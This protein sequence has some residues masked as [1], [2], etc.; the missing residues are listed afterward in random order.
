VGQVSRLE[1][2]VGMGPVLALLETRVSAVFIG[3]GDELRE[4]YRMVGPGLAPVT[5]LNAV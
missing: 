5:K 4:S 3:S 2:D 1:V